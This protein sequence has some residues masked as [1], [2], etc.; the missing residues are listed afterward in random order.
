M[1]KHQ[2][3]PEKSPEN[4]DFILKEFVRSASAFFGP[5]F[6]FGLCRAHFNC[7][8]EMGVEKCLEPICIFSPKIYHMVRVPEAR[9]I[10]K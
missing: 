4:S 7:T 2:K 3:Q 5:I 1:R 8:L 9:M 6:G 10:E